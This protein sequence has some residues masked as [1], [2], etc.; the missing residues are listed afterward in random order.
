MQNFPLVGKGMWVCEPKNAGCVYSHPASFAT[1][2]HWLQF[3]VDDAVRHERCSCTRGRMNVL[4]NVCRKPLEHILCQFDPKLEASEEGSSDVKYH[5]GTSLERVNHATNLKI[6]LS[7][8]ANPSHLEAC[9]PV[10]QG[11]TKA[12]QYYRGDTG[13]EKVELSSLL[14]RRSHRLLTNEIVTRTPSLEV[15]S[16][17]LVAFL[18]NHGNGSDRQFSASCSFLLRWP[19]LVGSVM[20]VHLSVP[21]ACSPWLTKGQHATRPVYILA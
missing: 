8:V 5:L 21:A 1:T 13:S 9:G 15:A 6:R 12:E 11:K 17:A 16:T 20:S 7:V 19:H 10:V 18:A 3:L 2:A 14:Y 4:A